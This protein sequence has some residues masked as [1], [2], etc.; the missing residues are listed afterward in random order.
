MPRRFEGGWEGASGR[1][2]C[3]I[4]D[5]SMGGCYVQ[6][7]AAPTPGD[8]TTVTVR[9]GDVTAVDHVSLD[10][11]E[12]DV[13]AV[14]GPSG[15]GKSTLLRAVAGLE[16]LSSGRVTSGGRDLHGVPAHRR[17]F[18]LMFQDGQLF[19]HLTVA[20][21]VALNRA[22]WTL[23]VVLV[24]ALAIDVMKAATL[25]FVMPGMSAEY[26][27]SKPTAITL[28]LV[29]LIGTTIGSIACTGR[30][31]LGGWLMSLSRALFRARTI[32]VVSTLALAGSALA[33]LPAAPAAATGG[34]GGGATSSFVCASDVVYSVDGSTHKISKVTPS[35]GGSTSAMRGCGA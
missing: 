6:T 19:P 30:T 15:S 4:S 24:V 17:G 31:Q 20:D 1:G 21:N 2:L 25:G 27:I 7:L 12:G 3:A 16:P 8:K 23:V 5:L 22:H 35:T 11:A 9:F 10:V 28:A 13:L 34:G 14:L 32:T 18:A 29:A 26:D 33:L